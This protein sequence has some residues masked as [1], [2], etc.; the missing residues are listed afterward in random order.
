MSKIDQKGIKRGKPIVGMS[1][2]GIL[3]A[4]GRPPVHATA[5]LEDDIWTY[6]VNRWAKNLLEFNEQGKLIKIIK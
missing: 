2:E 5:A 3:L 4:M 6:W 1:K